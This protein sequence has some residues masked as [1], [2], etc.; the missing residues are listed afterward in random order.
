ML[1]GDAGA[2]LTDPYATG[3]ETAQDWVKTQAHVMMIVPNA[4]DLEGLPTSPAGGEAYVMW[5]GTPYAHIM[6]PVKQ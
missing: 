5:K 1:Q 3:P 4:K 6:M 2:S